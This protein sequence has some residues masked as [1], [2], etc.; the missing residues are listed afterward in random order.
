[1]T[2]AATANGAT[3]LP[4]R[5]DTLTPDQEVA[6]K[7]T[8]VRI[9]KAFEQKGEPWTPPAK[10]AEPAKEKKS[11][12]GFGG[13]KKESENKDLFMGAT[14]NPDWLAL[15]VEQALPLIPGEEL[16]GTFWNMVAGDNADAVVLRFLRARKWDLDAAF[17][18]LMN[19]L[20]WR[21][22]SRVDDITALGEH[23]VK[24]ELNNLKPGMGDSFIENLH[25][26]KSVLGGPDKDGRPI[27]YINV[28]FHKKEDQDH[29]VIK[30]MTLYFMES[31]RMI[32]HQPVESSCIVFNM[33]GFTLA[34]MD[35]DFVKFLLH[36][37]EA[38]YPETL[39][40]CLI[41]KA[42]WVFS[43]VWNMITPLLDPVVASKI[44]FTK[45]LDELTNY[46]DKAILPSFI[47]GKEDIKK[48]TELPPLPPAGSL[49]SRQSPEFKQYEAVCRNYLAETAEFAKSDI[50]AHDPKR[51]EQALAVRHSTIKIEPIIRGR[52]YFHEIGLADVEN[53]RLILKFFGHIEP[54]DIS[55]C[56]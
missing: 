26:N 37:F 25:S 21:I 49:A 44:H 41:H 9:L 32:V 51:K 54:K 56:V 55:D 15:P 28:R 39:G 42:P 47:V 1:M 36:C 22:V 48:N 6:L 52:T 23:G 20:R 17:N 29:E 50:P 24:N 11:R 46:V 31:S 18:M 19:C 35:F 2:A 3:P 38:Y 13:G 8:W 14:K 34:N 4:G 45:N 40:S 53:D 43:T 27:S 33:E 12:W 7:K 10:V 5:I 16:A 30:V